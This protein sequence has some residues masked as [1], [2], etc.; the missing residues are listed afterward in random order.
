MDGTG[1]SGF[2]L[3]TEPEWLNEVDPRAVNLRPAGRARDDGAAGPVN[4]PKI[5]Y[6]PCHTQSAKYLKSLKYIVFKRFYIVN[7]PRI[8]IDLRQGRP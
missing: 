5:A 3:F 1:A 7:R 2:L 6:Q 8:R 4:H